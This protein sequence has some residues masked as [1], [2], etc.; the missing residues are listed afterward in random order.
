ML[1]RSPGRLGSPLVN[2]ILSL[3]GTPWSRRLARAALYLN[4]IRRREDEFNSL[5]DAEIRSTGLRLKGRARGGEKLTDLL[6]EAFG[7]VCV[8][9]KRTLGLRPFDVQLGAGAVMFGGALAEV[10][11]G[12]GKTLIAAL[13]AYLHALAGKGVHV[14]TVNDYLAK[15]DKE[16]LEPLYNSLG[17]SIGVLQQQMSESERKLA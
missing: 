6:P 9:A 4:D 14:A 11:T 8:A 12:E 5:S 15:R 7:L 16:W 17:L 3:I 1:F 13:P 10:A 2:R